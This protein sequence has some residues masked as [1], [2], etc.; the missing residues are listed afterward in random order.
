MITINFSTFILLPSSFSSLSVVVYFRDA[1][2]VGGL[3]WIFQF[4]IIHVS[5]I[6]FVSGFG[7]IR[8]KFVKIRSHNKKYKLLIIMSE[9]V[10]I[11]SD[12]W[13]NITYGA[14]KPVLIFSW[15][16]SCKKCLAI[17]S[18]LEELVEE[19]AD[20]INICSLNF[21]EFQAIAIEFGIHHP[22]SVVLIDEGEKVAELVE[23]NSTDAIVALID[24]RFPKD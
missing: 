4:L 14:D 3:L 12:G 22:A 6:S 19:L 2:L 8:I 18:M 17:R 13:A 21:Q 9:I 23:P 10:E 7:G 16:R 5:T 11:T 24:Q 20:R 1:T 15:R